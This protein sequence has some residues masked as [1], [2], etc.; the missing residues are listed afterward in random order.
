MASEPVQPEQPAQPTQPLP[1]VAP[2]QHDVDV[3]APATQPAAPG[4]QPPPD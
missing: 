4:V 2:P 1:E 3:P